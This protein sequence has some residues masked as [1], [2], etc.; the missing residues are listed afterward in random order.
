MAVGELS[1]VGAIH[2]DADLTRGV[3]ELF[4]AR[5]PF[6]SGPPLHIHR[7]REEAF[8]VVSGQYLLIRASEETQLGTGDFILIPRGTPHRFQALTDHAR[9][10]FIVS[11]PGLEGFFRDGAE[12]RNQGH[13]DAEVRRM[14][15]SRY[16][17]HPVN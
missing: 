5:T 6:G 12:L 7:E 15:T 9:L 3:Y 4:E 11:P 14:L 2:A 1:G 8:Y 10:L 13:S 17:S 16:D